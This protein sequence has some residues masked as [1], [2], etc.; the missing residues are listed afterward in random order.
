MESFRVEEN[1]HNYVM[2]FPLK[3]LKD[4]CFGKTLDTQNK[5]TN[6]FLFFFVIFWQ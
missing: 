5:N 2:K 1:A 4:F 6:T 3:H